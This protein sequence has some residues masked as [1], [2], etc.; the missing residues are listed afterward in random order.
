MMLELLSQSTWTHGGPREPSVPYLPAGRERIVAV[1]VALT[2]AT[3]APVDE[4]FALLIAR[5]FSGPIDC[6]CL[7]AETRRI[8]AVPGTKDCPTGLTLNHMLILACHNHH[9]LSVA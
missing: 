3:V 6:F 1:A 9:P 4:D 8:T 7:R 2:D 5:D